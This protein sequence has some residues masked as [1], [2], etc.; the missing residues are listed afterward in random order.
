MHS[1]LVQVWG[2]ANAM[3]GGY[4]WIT[5][6]TIETEVIDIET[7][8]HKAMEIIEQRASEYAF[9]VSTFKPFMNV[10]RLKIM[11][12]NMTE[13]KVTLTDLW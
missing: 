7:L 5:A 3:F 1:V 13:M 9:G 2:P 11:H 12:D 6:G 4:D 8:K 10:V